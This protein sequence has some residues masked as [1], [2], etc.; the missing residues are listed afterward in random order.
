M[1]TEKL[2]TYADLCPML[3]RSY[4]SIW[5]WVQN[6]TFPQPVKHLGRTIGWKQLDVENWIKESSES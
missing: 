3:N 1:N 4:K 5:R 6:G 2:L